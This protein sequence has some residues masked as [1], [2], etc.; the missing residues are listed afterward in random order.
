MADST[1][2]VQLPSEA[3]ARLPSAIAALVPAN[4]DHFM[5]ALEM[6][7]LAASADGLDETER[8]AIATTL[9]KVTG[10]G[11]DHDAFEAHF[12]DLDAAVLALGRRERLARTSAEFDNDD[13]RANVIRFAA[14]VAMADGV[15]NA[16]ELVVL[17]EVGSHFKWTPDRIRGLVTDAAARVQGG[18]R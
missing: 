17:E 8:D 16:P 2:I 5:A 18:D 12:S 10:I 1:V 13:T 14:L 9:E 15:L 3:L 4:T 6:G 7:Y 11:F